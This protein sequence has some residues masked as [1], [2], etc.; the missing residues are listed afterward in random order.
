[1]SGHCNML[2]ASCRMASRCEGARLKATKKQKLEWCSH[3]SISG[4]ESPE[5]GCQRCPDR[6]RCDTAWVCWKRKYEESKAR[7]GG[8]R[9]GRAV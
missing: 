4:M 9:R 5:H 3:W 6:E 2:G 8:R 7:G 1:M